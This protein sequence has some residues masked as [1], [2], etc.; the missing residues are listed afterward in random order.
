MEFYV[1]HIPVFSTD[2]DGFLQATAAAGS[3]PIII[4]IIVIIILIYSL[5]TRAVPALLD[6][7]RFSRAL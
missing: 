3:R 7:C 2:V 1:I 4:V 6:V 5:V